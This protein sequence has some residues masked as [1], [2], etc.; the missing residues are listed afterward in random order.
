MGDNRREQ[1]SVELRFEI[2]Q[3]RWVINGRND[4]NARFK[5]MIKMK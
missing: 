4:V 2:E 1:E 3:K 5:K